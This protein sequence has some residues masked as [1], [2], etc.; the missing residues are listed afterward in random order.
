MSW[1]GPIMHKALMMISLVLL[2]S[3]VS[4][5]AQTEPAASDG[6]ASQ[7]TTPAPAP[8]AQAATPTSTATPAPDAAQSEGV[9]PTPEQ[10]RAARQFYESLHRQT[11]AVLVAG[12]KVRLQIPPSHYFVG[13][14]DSRRILVDE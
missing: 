12:G 2:T 1:G 10:V 11:G 6:A 14:E 9:A 4:A 7:T 13:A 5:F 3:S 8:N